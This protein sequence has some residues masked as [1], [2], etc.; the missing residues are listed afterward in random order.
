[1]HRRSGGFTLIELLVVIS[2]IGVLVGLLLPAINSARESGRRAQCQNNMRQ[3][4]L[5]LT[6][7]LNVNGT[8]PV[9]GVITELPVPETKMNP[10]VPPIDVPRNQGIVSWHDPDCTPLPG[11]IPMYNWV[12]EIL[13]FIDSQDLGNAWNKT[14]PQTTGGAMALAYN[15]DTTADP[16]QI[17]NHRISSTSISLLRCPD[18]LNSQT[19]NGNLS[20]VVNGGFSLWQALPIG[21]I[22]S[23]SDGQSSAT[24]YDYSGLRLADPSMGWSGNVNIASK[25]GVMFLEDFG[26]AN[27]VPP[28]KMPWNLRTRIVDIYDG[29]SNTVLLSENTL[30]GAGPPSKYSKNVETN[31]ACPLANFCMF[32]GS[33]NICA[34][35]GQCIAGQLQLSGDQDGPGWARANQ[36]GTYENINYG[37]NL[38]I[39]GSF[40]FSNSGHPGL[41]N[42]LFCDGAVRSIRE[43]LDGTVY[44]KMLTK[45]GAR[46]PAYAKQLPLNQ[47]AFID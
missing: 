21:W 16:G 45:A 13:S 2:I 38:S 20:Y 30:A 1:M 28:S 23:A 40:P 7:F 33:D 44:S 4:G 29:A 15:D 9:A 31:W 37:R 34:P 5:G 3:L 22:G 19:G 32:I 46:L 6:G 41:C 12:V 43:T 8:Y 10:N 47:D 26:P 17:S 14:R 35:D 27:V 39:K 24:S 11:E 42:M 25:L 36:S 18:D